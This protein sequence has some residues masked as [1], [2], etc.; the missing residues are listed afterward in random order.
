MK[1]VSA[2]KKTVHHAEPV[3]LFGVGEHRFAISAIAV[4]E[5][6]NTDGLQEIGIAGDLRVPKVKYRLAR[7]GR[8]YWVVEANQ[9]FRMLPAP[10]TRLLVL[11]NSRVA[12]LVSHIDRMTEIGNVLALPHAFRGEERNWYRGLTVLDATGELPIVVPVVK[13]EGFLT[14]NE[15][16]ILEAGEPRKEAKGVA[17]A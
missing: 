4:E 17:K 3:I 5:I 7:D 11:R 16:Q 9:H 1:R 12:V 8:T 15:L 2:E 6:R 13:A 14:G 10:T